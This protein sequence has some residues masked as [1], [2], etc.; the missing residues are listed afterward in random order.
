VIPSC[1]ELNGSRS[2]ER[3]REAR[4]HH[5]VGVKPDTLQAAHAERSERVVILEVSEFALYGAAAVVEVAEVVA[6][7]GDTRVVARSERR[8]GIADSFVVYAD[9]NDRMDA[10]SLALAVR[11]LVVVSLVH[12]ARLRGVPASLHRV[13]KPSRKQRLAVF[14]GFGCPRERQPGLHT[15]GGVE[16]VAVVAATVAGGHGGA[17]PPTRVG[18]AVPLAF[19]A[20]TPEGALAI[21]ERREVGSVDC[22]F[23][24]DARN[25]VLKRCGD[26]VE[27]IG[28]RSRVLAQLRGEALAGPQTRTPAERRLQAGMVFDKSGNPRPGGEAVESFDEASADESAS[29]VTLATPGIAHSVDAFDQGG[30]FGRVQQGGKS[31][32]RPP[33]ALPCHLPQELHLLWSRPRRFQPRGGLFCVDLQD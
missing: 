30:Y 32:N 23:L 11:A 31:Q 26:S 16:F 5:K 24:T 20:V 29:A 18:I 6:V 8:G 19:R 33:D 17:A 9:R 27:T 12:G 25:G 28:Q 22:D 7:T 10:P 3:Q 13:E 14:R 21:R 1:G 4:E 15:D 2:T